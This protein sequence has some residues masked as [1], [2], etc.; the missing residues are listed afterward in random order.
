MIGNS[1]IERFKIITEEEQVYLSGSKEIDRCIY[2]ENGGN[3][4]NS[5]KLLNKGKLITLRPHT[6]FVDF[7]M[8]SHDYVEVMYV[9]KGCVIHTIGDTEIMVRE[10]EILFLGRNTK[11]AIKASS[12]NDIAVNFI[13]LPDFF[14]S[15]LEMLKYDVSPL[16]TFVLDSLNENDK[17]ECYMHFSVSNISAVQNLVENL[18]L[19]LVDDVSNRYT[20]SS[21]TMG[22]LLLNL[23][24]CTEN[25]KYKNDTDSA[26]I[27]VLQY[28]EENF[29]EGSLTE[30]SEMLHYDYNWL[31]REIKRK[32]GKTYTELVQDRRLSQAC[33]LLKNTN[34]NILDISANVGYDNISYFHTI[35][36]RKFNKTPREYRLS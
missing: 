29:R 21:Y 35:F 6:R 30:L 27:R 28:I 7:P 22:L 25:L 8:H 12:E 20:I 10:G 33:F 1:I 14:D 4:I 36:Y 11:H 3:I 9:C 18:I 34:M 17:K 13:I 31:S 16:K 23:V 19:A 15:P 5:K 2:T 32:T 24:N 26:A